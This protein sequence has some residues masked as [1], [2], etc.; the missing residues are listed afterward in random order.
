MQCNVN[1]TVNYFSVVINTNTGTLKMQG[2][3]IMTITDED[4]DGQTTIRPRPI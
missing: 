2:K 4:D 3:P 1:K